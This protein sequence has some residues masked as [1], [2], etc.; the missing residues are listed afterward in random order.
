[1]TVSQA[2]DLFATCSAAAWHG[3]RCS[4]ELNPMKHIPRAW[5]IRT[6]DNGRG[7][8]ACDGGRSERLGRESG[9]GYHNSNRTPKC[10]KAKTRIQ[11]KESG[12]IS[13]LAF[14]YRRAA[15][16]INRS[17]RRR[18]SLCALTTERLRRRHPSD[19]HVKCMARIWRNARGYF[20]EHLG[21]VDAN[22]RE[23]PNP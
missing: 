23:D 5:T 11:C 3:L 14:I 4:L 1:V 20:D 15:R 22:Y 13:T 16:K 18:C 2:A 21:Y 6:K 9:C 10:Y 12:M 8:S 7:L 17:K 19:H